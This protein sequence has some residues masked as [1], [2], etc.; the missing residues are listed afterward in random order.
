[1]SFGKFGISFALLVFSFSV[2]AE[3][4]PEAA[5]T[6]TSSLGQMAEPS[7]ENEYGSANK[8]LEGVPMMNAPALKSTTGDKSGAAQ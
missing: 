7:C 4:A 5:P 2:F 1:M 3:D 6:P 8:V